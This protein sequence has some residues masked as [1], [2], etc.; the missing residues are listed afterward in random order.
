MT[1]R[2]YYRVNEGVEAFAQVML[3]QLD[4]A[5]GIAVYCPP[6]IETGPWIEG[7]ETMEQA[8]DLASLL[9]KQNNQPAVVIT[10]DRLEW[11]LDGLTEIGDADDLVRELDR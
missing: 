7:F 6:S 4:G 5:G 10:Y 8:M 2:I 1:R 9:S 3:I 11:W